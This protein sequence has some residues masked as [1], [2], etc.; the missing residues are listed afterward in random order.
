MG[1]AYS[2]SAAFRPASE[3]GRKRN[4]RVSVPLYS[5]AGT[6]HWLS[7]AAERPGTP[8]AKE[9]ARYGYAAAKASEREVGLPAG[10]RH[11][12]VTRLETV[13]IDVAGK[14]VDWTFDT[15][16]TAAFPLSNVIPGAGGITVYVTESP[17]YSGS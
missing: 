4:V 2:P 1:R 9:A 17:L 11:L 6:N 13:R 7:H 8:T 5:E 14:R 3:A 16:G 10:S 12:N 15:F